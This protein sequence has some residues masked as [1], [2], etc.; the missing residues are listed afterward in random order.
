[1]VLPQGEGLPL[2]A[3]SSPGGGGASLAMLG[4][5]AWAMTT[6]LIFSAL[7][8]ADDTAPCRGS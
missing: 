3:V 1:M 8:T 6:D 5:A 7:E 2:L 4:P